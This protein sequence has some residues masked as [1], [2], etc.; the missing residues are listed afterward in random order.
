MTKLRIRG[1]VHWVNAKDGREAHGEAHIISGRRCKV[2]LEEVPIE[3][4]HTSYSA[5][6][7]TG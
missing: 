1:P 4:A 7:G 2:K 3:R 6:A 5:G